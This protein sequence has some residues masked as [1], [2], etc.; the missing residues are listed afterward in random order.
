M[1]RTPQRIKARIE[2]CVVLTLVIVFALT[3]ASVAS[4]EDLSGCWSGYWVSC[5]NGHRGPLQATLTRVDDAT[6]CAT[7]TGRFWRIV[8]F[9]YTTTLHVVE[10]TDGV[11][12]EGST[13]LGPLMGDYSYSATVTGNVLTASYHARRDFGYWHLERAP[14][15]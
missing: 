9:R 7:F 8:P 12:L 14:G 13:F 5:T 11:R 4:A 10:T 2:R 3:T 6:Y 15:H 1:T